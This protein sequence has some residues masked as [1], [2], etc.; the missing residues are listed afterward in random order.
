MITPATTTLED[1]DISVHT[2]FEST[3]TDLKW[4]K[5]NEYSCSSIKGC[6]IKTDAVIIET[7][8]SSVHVGAVT[9]V[10]SALEKICP[11]PWAK[12]DTN[13]SDDTAS[14]ASPRRRNRRPRGRSATSRLGDETVL[15]PLVGAE[16][17]EEGP[18]VPYGGIGDVV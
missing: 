18:P 10:L 17:H 12:G 15:A 5:V 3:A 9:S 11:T 1:R 7:G 13:C 4:C 2:G 16:L 6:F 8:S 14:R